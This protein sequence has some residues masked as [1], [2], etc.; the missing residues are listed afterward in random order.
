MRVML[1]LFFATVVMACGPRVT[2]TQCKDPE[3]CE[4]QTP[5]CYNRC[6]HPGASSGCGDCCAQMRKNCLNCESYKF[7]RCR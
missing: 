4:E 5:L 3:W 6:S 2:A 1:V 7:D